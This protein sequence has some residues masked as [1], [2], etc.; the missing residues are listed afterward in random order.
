MAKS[1]IL[2]TLS[3]KKD[4]KLNYVTQIEQNKEQPL[5]LLLIQHILA[6][7]GIGKI[8]PAS[9]IRDSTPKSVKSWVNNAIP[10]PKAIAHFMA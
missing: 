5:H 7:L 10:T 1:N 8:D 9:V 4:S 6:R 2:C 3:L